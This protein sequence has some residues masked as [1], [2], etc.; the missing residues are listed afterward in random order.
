M[1]R[2]IGLI[3]EDKEN[4]SKYIKLP[5]TL[6]LGFIEL[7]WMRP[8]GIIGSEPFIP[9]KDAELPGYSD[10]RDSSLWVNYNGMFYTLEGLEESKNFYR[11]TFLEY[12]EEYMRLNK[13]RY[14]ES[15]YKFS[16]NEKEDLQQDISNAFHNYT[17]SRN[18]SENMNQ[19]YF[20]FKSFCETVKL[21]GDDFY[22]PKNLLLYIYEE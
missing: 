5:I 4:E 16:A 11:N 8:N 19:L 18:D 14:S 13:L 22:D 6:N 10:P 3:F 20:M 17:E 12:K 21:E 15:Y 2:L 9:Q 1:S 7:E